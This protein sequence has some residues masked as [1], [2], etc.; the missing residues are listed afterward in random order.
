MFFLAFF[1]LA[2]VFVLGTFSITCVLLLLYRYCGFFMPDWLTGVFARGVIWVR[3][4]K[5]QKLAL[6]ALGISTPVDMLIWQSLWLWTFLIG[7]IGVL[8]LWFFS[9]S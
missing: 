3:H 2:L 8:C 6:I 9:E 7:G 5:P 4:Q 1:G